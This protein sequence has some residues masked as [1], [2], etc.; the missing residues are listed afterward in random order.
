MSGKWHICRDCGKNL[1]SYYSLWRHKKCC[2][3]PARAIEEKILDSSYNSSGMERQDKHRMSNS[4]SDS[5]EDIIPN[6]IPTFD[7]AEFSGEKPKSRET[8]NRMME[9]L[10]IPEHRWEKIATDMLKEDRERVDPTL[11][12]KEL[13][14]LEE[15]VD[16]S[17][18]GND[19]DNGMDESDTSDKSLADG[20]KDGEPLDQAAIKKLFNR[21]KL[22]HMI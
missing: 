20:D 22:L 10:K 6:Q 15:V 8:L 19:A 9:M 12:T 11:P 17:E 7:G 21:F 4:L 2:K 18:D 13:L 16:E 1:A 5:E 3:A 14:P